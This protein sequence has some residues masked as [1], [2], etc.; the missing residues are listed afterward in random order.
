MGTSEMIPRLQATTRERPWPIKM[1]GTVAVGAAVVTLAP[2]A[3]AAGTA[4]VSEGGITGA[5]IAATTTE[6]AAAETEAVAVLSTATVSAM[7]TDGDAADVV[8]SALES[9]ASGQVAG[10]VSAGKEFKTAGM[11]IAP[12][13]NRTSNPIG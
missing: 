8:G 2:A 4:V 13:D 5:T 10:W 6:Y 7:L 1:A 3:V 12:F 11:R 9:G